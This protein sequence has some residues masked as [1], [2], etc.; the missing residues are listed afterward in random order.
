MIRLALAAIQSWKSWRA[1]KRLA[2]MFPDVVER[3]EK[4]AVR[5]KQH[6]S[7]R[8]IIAENYRDMHEALGLRIK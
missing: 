7:T 1:R 4:I 2:R 8:S 6:R 3:Q 5:R